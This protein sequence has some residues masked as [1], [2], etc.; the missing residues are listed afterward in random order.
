MSRKIYVC[1]ARD[2]DVADIFWSD[3]EPVSSN[4][5]YNKR[6]GFCEKGFKNKEKAII[7]TRWM[8]RDYRLIKNPCKSRRK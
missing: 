8:N 7:R 1:Y 6:Y 2:S 3:K 5:C 4:N